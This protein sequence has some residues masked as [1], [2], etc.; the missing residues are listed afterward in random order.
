LTDSDVTIPKWYDVKRCNDLPQDMF[1]Y[2]EILKCSGHGV[3]S[4]NRDQTNPDSCECDPGYSGSYCNT[5]MNPGIKCGDTCKPLIKRI[6]MEDSIY[7]ENGSCSDIKSDTCFNHITNILFDKKQ[8]N[9][10]MDCRPYD[11][12]PDWD[13]RLGDDT[14]NAIKLI[15]NEISKDTNS[16]SKNEVISYFNKFKNDVLDNIVEQYQGSSMDLTQF[17]KFYKEVILIKK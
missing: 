12:L 17:T 5:D 15:F 3:C 1:S 9:C 13:T 14:D 6:I 4:D 16:I 7:A 8:L 2:P 10:V 11:T